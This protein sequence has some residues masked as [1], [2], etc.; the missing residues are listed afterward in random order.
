MLTLSELQQFVDQQVPAGQPKAPSEWQYFGDTE[1]NT[2]LRQLLARRLLRAGELAQAE[3]YFVEPA[4]QQLAAR[5]HDAIKQSQ[6]NWLSAIRQYLGLPDVARATALFQAASL[7]RQHGLEL[8]GFELAPDYQVFYGQFEFYQSPEASPQ[9]WQIP[10]AEQQRISASSAVPDKR[11]HYRYLAAEL[12]A[13]SADWLPHNSQAFA[14]TLC[15]ASTW[16]INR[17]PALAQQY[18]QRYL[19]QG[20]YVSWGADIGI[21]CPAPDFNSAATRASQNLQQE[22]R[23]QRWPLLSAGLFGLILFG[24]WWWRRRR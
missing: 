23:Q 18:Y 11:F 6:P 22:F 13:Q 7:T 17:D 15:H 14:A 20:P 8:L 21:R 3:R 2:L 1:P 12:A 9:Q 16:L 5:Y 10:L 19:A 4:L 24:G